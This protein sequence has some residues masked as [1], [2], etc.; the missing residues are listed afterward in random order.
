MEQ[1]RD[2]PGYEGIYQASN[3]GRVRTCE[4]KVTSNARCTH[5]VW[6]QRI[7]K[8]KIRF[9]NAS[10]CYADARVDLWKDGEKKTC[11]VAR[12]VA[13]TWCD[14]YAHGLTVD[15]QD[16]NPLNNRADNLRW[17]TMAENIRSGYE[18]GFYPQIH[19]LLVDEAGEKMAFRS[20]R[21]AGRYL[22]CSSAKMSRLIREKEPMYGKYKI[23]IF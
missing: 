18:K 13:I 19:I 10:T 21:S 14:G 3:E 6:K 15:H 23:F 7:L 9:R 17:V 1:W 20:L 4:G 12:L 22:G 5:R 11:L 16:G 2:I 8:H